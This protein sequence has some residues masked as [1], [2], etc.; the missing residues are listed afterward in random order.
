[1][2]VPAYFTLQHFVLYLY[3]HILNLEWVTNKKKTW[4]QRRRHVSEII[5][6]GAADDFVSR[7]YDFLSTLILLTNVAV[8]VLYTFDEME[9]RY[10][11]ILLFLEAITMVFFRC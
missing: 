3:H 1:M 2:A 4:L 7:E 5:E 6:V 9:L 11:Q 8:T 10:G